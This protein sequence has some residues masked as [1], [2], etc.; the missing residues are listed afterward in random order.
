VVIGT[1]GATVGFPAGVGWALPE[2]ELSTSTV[3]LQAAGVARIE[4]GSLGQ[5]VCPA[6]VDAV[7]GAAAAAL[8]L[9][10]HEAPAPDAGH[11]CPPEGRLTSSPS[12]PVVEQDPPAS[13]LEHSGI[14][15]CCGGD[16]ALTVGAAAEAAD[17][18][19]LAAKAMASAR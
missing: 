13:V 4:P 14:A 10:T 11:C 3:S 19:R 2:A 7:P 18:S 15:A 1:L 12:D 16:A 17:G 9:V 6:G 8:L 5:A